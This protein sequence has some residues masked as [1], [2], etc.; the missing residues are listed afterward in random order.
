MG[1]WF[2]RLIAPELEHEGAEKAKRAAEEHLI[3]NGFVLPARQDCVLGGDGTGFPPGPRFQELFA[4]PVQ[5]LGLWTNGV[6][7]S[8]TRDIEFADPGQTEFA[9]FCPDCRS[10]LEMPPWHAWQQAMTSYMSGGSGLL[11]C[12]HCD[13]THRVDEWV[14]VPEVGFT[15]FRIEFWN[16][17]PLRQDRIRE[18]SEAV[19]CRLQ[20]VHGK[21]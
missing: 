19:G 14:Y 5:S 17:P 8:A 16:T 6:R 7:I 21:L 12:P 11:R 3:S 18:L 15:R 4:R 2:I 1:D 10:R 13:G 9:L 20:V